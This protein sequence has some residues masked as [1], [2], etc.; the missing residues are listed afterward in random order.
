MHGLEVE[1]DEP[2]PIGP[3]QC[4]RCGKE[5]PRHELACVWCKQALDHAGAEALE[6][7]E[8]KIREAVL[9][10]AKDHP[11]LL[12]DVQGTRDF[13]ELLEDNPELFS[14]AQEFLEKQNAE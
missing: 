13:S 14:D 12:D 10:F 6:E 5:T 7:D 11:E 9:R 3:V 4:P 8:R 1:E 2:E